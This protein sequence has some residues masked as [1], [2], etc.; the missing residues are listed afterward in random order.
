MA[1]QPVKTLPRS[2]PLLVGI[3]AGI[4]VAFVVEVQLNALDIRVATAWSQLTSGAPLRFASASVYWAIAGC[5][6]VGGAIAAGLL[7]RFPPPWR[8][9]RGLRWIIGAAIVF[10]L[11]V[12][13]GEIEPPHGVGLGTA[14]MAD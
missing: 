10:G 3:T 2:L 14:V 6:F 5:S 12:V 13:A 9:F 7:V 1:K 11:A 8:N 4:F